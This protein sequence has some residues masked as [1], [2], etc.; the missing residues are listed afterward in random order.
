MQVFMGFEVKL[1]ALVLPSIVAATMAFGMQAA[2]QTASL[3]WQGVTFQT[4]AVD[5]DTLIFSI[6]NATNATGNWSDVN[7]LKGFEIKEVGDVTGVV[8][9]DPNSVSATDFNMN[10]NGCPGTAGNQGLCFLASTPIALTDSMTWEIT[11]AGT[12]LDFS[13]PHIKVNFYETLTQT[14]AT[15]DLLSQNLTTPIPEPETYAM[16]LAGLALMGFVA[17]R[18]QRRFGALRPA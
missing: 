13:S 17:R 5:S 15:G 2:A 12:N 4:Q 16:L 3:T 8:S 7:Y 1:R 9:I 6:L 18:R 14:K 10:A 11:F